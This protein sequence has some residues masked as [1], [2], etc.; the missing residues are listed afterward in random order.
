MN[1]VVQKKC[2]ESQ[3]QE[4]EVEE[5]QPPKLIIKIML[6]KLEKN[7]LQKERTLLIWE[8]QMLEIVV[9]T[10]RWDYIKLKKSLY[11]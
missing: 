9:K 6:E 1:E 10:E 3:I 2:S 5:F 7:N 8:S 11:V 4:D